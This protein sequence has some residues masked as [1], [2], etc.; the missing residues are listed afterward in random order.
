MTTRPRRTLALLAAAQGLTA[1]TGRLGVSALLAFSLVAG[2]IGI[3][4]GPASGALGSSLAACSSR[5]LIFG[6]CAFSAYVPS[7]CL[8][9]SSACD[10]SSTACTSAV[11]ACSKAPRRSRKTSPPRC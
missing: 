10:S 4:D 8:S 9:C 5:A 1:H 11:T 3:V 7:T 6:A 2:F